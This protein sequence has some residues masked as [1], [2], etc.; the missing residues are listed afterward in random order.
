MARTQRGVIDLL[1]DYTILDIQGETPPEED[2]YETNG[3]TIW[4][5]GLITSG[6]P[7]DAQKAWMANIANNSDLSTFPTDWISFGFS[8]TQWEEIEIWTGGLWV[9]GALVTDQGI[10]APAWR[11]GG[12]TGSGTYYWSEGSII[13]GSQMGWRNSTA[14]PMRRRP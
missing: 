7:T 6:P 11:I 8:T 3:Y 12:V 9:E 5:V 13:D 10:T 2:F 14:E 1:F 4:G